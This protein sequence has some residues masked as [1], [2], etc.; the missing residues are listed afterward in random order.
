MLLSSCAVDLL[1][2]YFFFRGNQKRYAKQF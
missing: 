2:L 1:K